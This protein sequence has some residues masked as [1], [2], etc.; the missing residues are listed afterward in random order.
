MPI[1]EVFPPRAQGSGVA[2]V[3]TVP[4]PPEPEIAP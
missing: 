3:A 4:H 2:I 1:N